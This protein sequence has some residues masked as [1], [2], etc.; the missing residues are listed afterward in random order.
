MVMRTDPTNDSSPIIKRRFKPMDNPT[1]VLDV[2]QSI[3]IIKEGVSGNNVTTGPNQYNYWRGCLEGTALRKFNEFSTLVGTETSAH[4]HEVEQRLVTY[5]SPREVLSQQTRYIRYSMRKPL[6]ATTRQYVG[7]VH[8]LNQTLK[9]LP[10]AFAA[11]QEIPA[12]DIMDILA[13]KAPK[14]HKELITDHG[15]DPQTATT[16]EFVEICERAET[17]EVI[18]QARSSKNKRFESDDDSSDNEPRKKKKV[19]RKPHNQ[20]E[21]PRYDRSRYFCKEHGPNNTHDSKDCKVL[22]AQKRGEKPDWKKKD[23]SKPKYKDYQSKYKKK[24]EELHLLQK[25][26][27]MEKAKWTK[28]WKSLKAKEKTSEGNAASEGEVSDDPKKKEVTFTPKEHLAEA[29]SSSSSSSSS[30]DS[31][32]DSDSETE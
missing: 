18:Q 10:P 13:S 24:N 28:A 30:S 22:L 15:F 7:A 3:L 27:K 14:N 12:S 16:E 23:S 25:E 20:K 29:E 9:E 32:T 17:K 26:T 4:L 19:H 1:K 8:T 2:L 31:S 6:D 5:F 21:R 11:T